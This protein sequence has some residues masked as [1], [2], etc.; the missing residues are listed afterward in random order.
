MSNKIQN[1]VTNAYIAYKDEAIKNYIKN[2]YEKIYGNP[3][4]RVKSIIKDGGFIIMDE[5][6]CVLLGHPKENA[7]HFKEIGLTENDVEIYVLNN[8]PLSTKTW[9]PKSLIG[10]ENNNGWESLVHENCKPTESGYY[11]IKLEDGGNEF[12][13]YYALHKEKFVDSDGEHF[14]LTAITHYKKVKQSPS[15]IH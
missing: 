2:A 12:I 4:K 15:P 1:K 5:L 9:R 11:E 8:A 13:C 6:Q 10:V 3:Y 14:P 7:L